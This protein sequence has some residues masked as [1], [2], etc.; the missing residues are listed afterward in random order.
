MNILIINGSARENGF[1]NYIATSLKDELVSYNT[2]SKKKEV[3]YF[4][5]P[6]KNINFCKGCVSCC[7]NEHTYCF[8]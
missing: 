5:I 2:I 3:N 6:N 1:C 7:N 8:I 4:N